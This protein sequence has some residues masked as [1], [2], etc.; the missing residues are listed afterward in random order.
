MDIDGD[1]AASAIDQLAEMAGGM[2]DDVLRDL[3]RDAHRGRRRADQHAR[4]Q[5][6]PAV[7]GVGRL[8]VFLLTFRVNNDILNFTR[9]S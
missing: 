6:R 4:Q 1:N 2:I 9:H 5:Q 8:A 3:R 7:E